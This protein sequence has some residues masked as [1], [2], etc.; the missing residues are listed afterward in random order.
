MEFNIKTKEKHHITV[1]DGVAQIIRVRCLGGV[2]K[3]V[4]LELKPDEGFV[5]AMS[6]ITNLCRL[7]DEVFTMMAEHTRV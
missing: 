2:P 6:R 5:D 3:V 4:R 7:D 1:S